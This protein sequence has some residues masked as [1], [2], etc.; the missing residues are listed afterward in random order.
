MPFQPGGGGRLTDE[1]SEPHSSSPPRYTNFH[2]LYPQPF[3]YLNQ[4]SVVV[5][6]DYHKIWYQVY[7][8]LE[9]YDFYAHAN[10]LD[11]TLSKI[12]SNSRYDIC[13]F[14]GGGQ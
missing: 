1:F 8:G 3:S 14:E 10:E 12:Y 7:F 4:Q 11:T 5:F 13:W 6:D 9:E 2:R